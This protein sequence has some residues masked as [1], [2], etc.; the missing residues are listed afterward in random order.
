MRKQTKT[1]LSHT[2]KAALSV[3]LTALL[4]SLLFLSSCVPHTPAEPDFGSLTGSVPE[5]A[6]ESEDLVRISPE[7]FELIPTEPVVDVHT[8][9]QKAFLSGP[10]EQIGKYADGRH[11]CSKPEPLSLVWT[12][13]TDGLPDGVPVPDSFTVF[14]DQTEAFDAPLVRT[15]S[16]E[17]GPDYEVFVDN[18][19]LDTD[20][21][22]KVHA[23]CG[24]KAYE[25]G[26]L[27]FKTAA[28]GPRNLNVGGVSNVRDLGGWVI[29]EHHR[30]KQG[31]LFR[32]AAF[33]DLQYDTHITEDGI[34]TV[35]DE[36]GV[37]T[38]I[39]LRWVS[40]GEIE[41][42]SDSLLGP[43]VRYLEFEFNY[44]DETLLTANVMSIA[45][46]FRR[47]AD[48]KY[49]PIYYHCRIGTD[50]TGVLTYLLLGFLGVD[51]ETLLT[52]YLFSN[53][54]YVG[55]NRSVATIQKAYID[56]ID[57]CEGETLQEKI[58]WY[59]INRCGMTEYNLE[60]IRTLLIE[61][62]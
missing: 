58:T 61:E 3:L 57:E 14:L 43:D 52:D 59:L 37:K 55:G 18:L 48:E 38:E 21:Y 27:S 6:A 49:Y 44:T 36:L 51:K 22:W 56:L 13:K 23:E 2:R 54:G 7:L 30:V 1:T 45:K 35:R 42:R 33:E 40:V 53:F 10:Y 28:N 16:A 26:V 11:E 24:E 12:F 9:D 32:G 47:F 50:R 41:H 17:D 34:R 29:D 20:Y 62:F 15:V 25:S 4:F 5:S 39:E 60:K 31:M 46:C 8:E 19:Y